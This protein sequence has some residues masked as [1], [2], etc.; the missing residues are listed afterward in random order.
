M[1]ILTEK[2]KDKICEQITKELA[3]MRKPHTDAR[4][5]GKKIK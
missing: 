3:E 4:I 5:H 1:I 2:Q